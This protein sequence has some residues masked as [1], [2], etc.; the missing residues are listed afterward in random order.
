MIA[1]VGRGVDVVDGWGS[2]WVGGADWDEGE[3]GGEGE[4]GEGEEVVDEVRMHGYQGGG[5][6]WMW[7]GEGGGSMF[8][9]GNLEVFKVVL[10]LGMYGDG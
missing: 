9:L 7:C 10:I 8:G 4:Q 5:G 6:G 3:G 1:V 2:D